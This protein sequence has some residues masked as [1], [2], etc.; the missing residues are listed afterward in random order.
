[1][2][3]GDSKAAIIILNTYVNQYLKN[4]IVINNLMPEHEK[5][6]K[7]FSALFSTLRDITSSYARSDE[8][9]LDSIDEIKIKDVYN[10]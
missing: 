8:K 3:Q 7:L 1:M 5:L 9:K 6:E 10:A 4:N 2:S